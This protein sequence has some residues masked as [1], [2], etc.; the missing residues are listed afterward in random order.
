VTD[1]DDGV[2]P[3][4]RAHGIDE[5]FPPLHPGTIA[6]LTWGDLRGGISVALALSLPTGPNRDVI[7]G[8]TCAVVVFT[9][10]VQE[11]NVGALVKRLV[12]REAS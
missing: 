5:A 2:A 1:D 4:S 7:L 11:L 9:I 3:M 10:I 8:V 12:A 6:I